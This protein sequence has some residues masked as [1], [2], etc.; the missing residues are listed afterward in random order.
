LGTTVY[1]RIVEHMVESSAFMAAG[2]CD[3]PSLD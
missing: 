3:D 2:H 1:D